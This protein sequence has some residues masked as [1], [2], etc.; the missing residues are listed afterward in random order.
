MFGFLVFQTI[1]YPEPPILLSYMKS[2]LGKVPDRK[3]SAKYLIRHHA[4][5]VRKAKHKV[6]ALQA[7]A[8]KI[9]PEFVGRKK[10]H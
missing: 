6:D 9:K 2:I 10:C 8:D 3:D 4:Q 7:K 5:I 1:K